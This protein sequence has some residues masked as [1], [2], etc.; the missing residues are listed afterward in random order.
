MRIVVELFAQAIAKAPRRAN[1]HSIGSV[2]KST[3]AYEAEFARRRYKVRCHS[4]GT[5]EVVDTQTGRTTMCTDYDTA[6]ARRIE[7]IVA[8][9]I[10]AGAN[11]LA[12][13]L[14]AQK[15]QVLQ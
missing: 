3:A 1:R 10:N 8:A 7:L 14:A 5:A 2:V 13:Q 15:D 12:R 6:D 11:A 9:G 4:S